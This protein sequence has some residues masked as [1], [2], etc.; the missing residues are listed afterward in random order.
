MGMSS[1]DENVQYHPYIYYADL[2]TGFHDNPMPR[3]EF[4]FTSETP[5]LP[6]VKKIPTLL[7]PC[8]VQAS[9]SLS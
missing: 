1:N 9:I 5:V 7:V 8:Q 2:H 6:T 4:I 3:F